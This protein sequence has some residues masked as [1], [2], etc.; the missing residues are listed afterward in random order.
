MLFYSDTN[1]LYTGEMGR[2]TIQ[3]VNNEIMS[4]NYRTIFYKL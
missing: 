3:W 2:C 4:L 1:I